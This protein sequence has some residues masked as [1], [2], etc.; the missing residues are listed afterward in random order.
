[1]EKSPDPNAQV[2][3]PMGPK[4]G[5]A[6]WPRPCWNVGAQSPIEEKDLSEQTKYTFSAHLD[7]INEEDL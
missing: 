3:R 1:M 4:Q 2:I 5:H 6:P 7:C